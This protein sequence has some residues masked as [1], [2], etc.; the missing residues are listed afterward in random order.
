MLEFYDIEINDIKKIQ[1]IVYEKNIISSVYSIYNL[2]LLKQKYNTKISYFKNALFIQQTSRNIG[3]YNI[4]LFPLSENKLEDDISMLQ[5]N[6]KIVN[7]NLT[8][9]G[10]DYEMIQK[11]KKIFPNDFIYEKIPNWSEYIYEKDEICK[12]KAMKKAKRFE[13]D[14]KKEYIIEEISKS[15]LNEIIKFQKKWMVDNNNNDDICSLEFEN[16]AILE[17][18]TIWEQLPLKGYCIKINGIVVGY[19]YGFLQTKDSFTIHTIK[20]DKTKKGLTIFLL[21]VI[22]EPFNIKFINFEED[23]GI[24]GLRIFKERLKPTFM[25]NKYVVKLR[26]KQREQI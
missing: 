5:Q 8:L 21:K 15:N 16:N 14:Y 20:S 1:K 19:V 6:A 2:L 10:L 3:N 9:W 12:C 17:T 24:E 7:S 4:Y 25:I 23:I 18:L 11:F 26:D 22:I 13:K